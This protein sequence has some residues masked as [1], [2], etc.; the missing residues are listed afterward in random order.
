MQ[1]ITPN[2]I[3]AELEG[4]KALVRRFVAEGIN[5]GNLAVIDEVLA[6]TYPS[7]SAGQSGPASIKE[8][9]RAYR[10]AVPDGCWTIQE[11]VAEDDTVVTYFIASGTQQGPLWGLPAT[12]KPMAVAGILMSRCRQNRIVDQWLRLDLLSLL[13][14]LGVM[15]ELRLADVVLVARLLHESQAR[16]GVTLMGMP[17]SAAIR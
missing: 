16:A 15:P 13:Q 6:P 8:V 11:Q 1:A 5:Q 10:G 4:T 12:R 9:L 17:S 2:W 14:Q 7:L 3:G